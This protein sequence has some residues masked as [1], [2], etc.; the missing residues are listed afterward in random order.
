M[1]DVRR[2]DLADARALEA[3]HPAT[4][5]K[6]WGPALA[7]AGLASIIAKTRAHREAI[8]ETGLG[9]YYGSRST[10]A[11]LT[12]SQQRASV[13]ARAKPGM[14]ARVPQRS[15]CIGWA[16][17]NLEAAYR[18]V[19][20]SSRWNAISAEVIRKQG[21]GDVLARELQKDGWVSV[22]WNPNERRPLNGNAEHSFTARQVREG[23]PYYGIQVEDRLVD[24][25]LRASELEPLKRAPF[26][27]GLAE[28][29]K[30]TFVGHGGKVSELHWAAGPEDPLAIEERTLERF[31]WGS[32]LLLVPPGTWSRAGR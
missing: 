12:A 9:R 31:P 27:F 14:P 19:G 11:G 23:R 13:Q 1:T 22:Y 15:D 18:A 3:L 8:S 17:E 30:H 32:G 10:F 28:G 20:R 5:G 26:F 29:G 24:Y 7:S 4:G 6:D 21:R 25:A 16:M 2:V